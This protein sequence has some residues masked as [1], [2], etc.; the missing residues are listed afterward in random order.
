M[1]PID[2]VVLLVLSL[3]WGASYLFIRVAVPVFGP[4]TL[5]VLR[6]ALGAALLW[7]FALALRRP[8]ELR[9]HAAPLLLLGLLNAALPYLLISAAELRLTASFAA[10]LSATTPLFAAGFGAVWLD[11]R[12]TPPRIAGLFA[13]IVGVAVMVG[14]SP[15]AL[16]TASLALSILAMLAASASYAASG[17]YARLRLRDVPVHTLA[18]GQQL[19]AFAWLVVPGIVL[20][21][22][23]APSAV[24]IWSVLALGVLSTAVAYLLYFR[25]LERVGPTKTSTVTYLVPMVGLAWGAV[26]LDEPMSGGMFVGLGLVLGSV[27]L[28]NEVRIGKPFARLTRLGQRGTRAARSGMGVLAAGFIGLAAACRGEVRMDESAGVAAG[29]GEAVRVAMEARFPPMRGGELRMSLIEVTY[30]PGGFS[31]PHSHRCPVIGHVI[32]GALRFRVAE[33]A[34][35]VY[36]AGESFHEAASERHLVS[37]NASDTEPVIFLAYFLCDDDGPRT[38]AAGAKP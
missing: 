28:V 15:V 25:L 31:S 16:T 26:F 1:T 9:R 37:A 38:V 34:D 23:V 7:G 3:V 22:S 19:G 21:P 27:V 6:V 12:L 2:S 36:H 35:T 20:A 5:V 8:V 18:L 10:V 33:N 14:W 17:I 11:E 29:R 30:A 24:A 13:G 32:A 4:A